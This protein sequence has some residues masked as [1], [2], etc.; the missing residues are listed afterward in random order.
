MITFPM[1]WSVIAPY[2]NQEVNL[3][4]HHAWM[5]LVITT[6]MI[7]EEGEDGKIGQHIEDFD[8]VMSKCVRNLADFLMH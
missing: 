4:E 3:S 7:D 2:I 1:S 5:I 6:K 8:A